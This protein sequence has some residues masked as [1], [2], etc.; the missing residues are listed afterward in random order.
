MSD[1]RCDCSGWMTTC[2]CDFVD[3]PFPVSDYEAAID[4]LDGLIRLWD[5]VFTDEEKP[6]PY[7]KAVAALARLRGAA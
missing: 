5:F 2:A 1:A 7:V 3:V 6:A 4:A